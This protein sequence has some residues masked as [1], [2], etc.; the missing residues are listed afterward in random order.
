[1]RWVGGIFGNWRALVL[2]RLRPRRKWGVGPFYTLSSRRLLAHAVLS[3]LRIRDER[4][5]LVKSDEFLVG[6]KAL[7]VRSE[8][9]FSGGRSAHL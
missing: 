7:L 9:T 8:S 5:F 6:K 3:K 1:M 2:S 4:L